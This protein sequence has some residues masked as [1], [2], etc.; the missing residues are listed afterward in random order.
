MVCS[1]PQYLLLV[2]AYLTVL[3]TTKPVVTGV[4]IG[5]KKGKL[6]YMSEAV[7]CLSC[8]VIHILNHSLSFCLFSL[9]L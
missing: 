4:K 9:F 6:L 7:F 8:V 3:A 2:L 5:G 1:M